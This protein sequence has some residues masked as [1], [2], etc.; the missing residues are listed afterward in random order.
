MYINAERLDDRLMLGAHLKEEEEETMKMKWAK[1]ENN[2]LD[3]N[4][5]AGSKANES[6]QRDGDFPKKENLKFWVFVQWHSTDIVWS[7]EA[8]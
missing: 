5:S 1:C 8:K 7:F 2:Q 6:I 4:F 3:G